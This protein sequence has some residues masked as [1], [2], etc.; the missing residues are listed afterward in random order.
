MTTSCS[1]PCHFSSSTLGGG[2][3]LDTYN[4]VAVAAKNGTL[5]GSIKHDG[6]S[7][8]PKDQPK[9]DDCRIAKIEAWVKAG[10][11]NN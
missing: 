3:L 11:P 7:A 1:A 4:S 5:V 6:F 2:I 9:L 8:M 10:S